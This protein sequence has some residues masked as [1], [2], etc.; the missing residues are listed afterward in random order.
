MY[1]FDVVK[2]VK[3]CIEDGCNYEH[4]KSNLEWARKIDGKPVDMHKEFWGTCEGFL[5]DEN[6]CKEVKNPMMFSKDLYLQQSLHSAAW[7]NRIDGKIVEFFDK[8][9]RL[10]M[11]EGHI[12]LKNWCKNIEL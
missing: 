9:D 8:N 10:G 6:W 1:I 3:S 7:C 4:I 12:V 5:I 11:C 2:F